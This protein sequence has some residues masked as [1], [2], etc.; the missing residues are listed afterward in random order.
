MLASPGTLLL[1][2]LM[3]VL[4]VVG[5]TE[6]LTSRVLPPVIGPQTLTA[7]RP[8]FT[9]L[10]SDGWLVDAVCSCV[11][12][13]DRAEDSQ[14]MVLMRSGSGTVTPSVPRHAAWPA[15]G[16]AGRHAPAGTA[17]EI[18]P[19][20]QMAAS[21]LATDLA[22]GT[23]VVSAH[24]G[25]TPLQPDGWDVRWGLMEMAAAQR[26]DWTRRCPCRIEPRAILGRGPR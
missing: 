20:P 3:G 21:Y 9:S 14:R 12:H 25:T 24:V 17:P 13:A 18:Q 15:A 2:T 7:A 26:R 5:R 22:G 11:R 8:H 4:V 10:R 1:T 23:P 16:G 6:T 19:R